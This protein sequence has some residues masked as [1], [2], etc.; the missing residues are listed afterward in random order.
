MKFGEE[1]NQLAS[2]LYQLCERVVLLKE[3]GLLSQDPPHP[4]R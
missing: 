1:D 4:L 3:V 2:S